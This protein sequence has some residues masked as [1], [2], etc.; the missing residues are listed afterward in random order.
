MVVGAVYGKEV[1]TITSVGHVPAVVFSKDGKRIL[2]WA[3]DGSGGEGKE[4]TSVNIYEVATGNQVGSISDSGRSV[5][6][7]T[8]TADGATIAMGATDG[9]V[10][11]FEASKETLQGLKVSDRVEAKRRPES[12]WRAHVLGACGV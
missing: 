12:K 4:G 8:F 6:S 11:E 10:H 5:G 9:T 3:P 1:R 2:A 7:L